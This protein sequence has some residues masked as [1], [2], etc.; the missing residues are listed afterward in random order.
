MKRKLRIFL[1]MMALPVLLVCTA[2]AT[3]VVTEGIQTAGRTTANPGCTVTYDAATGKYTASTKSGII[4]G[5]QYALLVVK[6]PAAG[7]SRI[8]SE[9]TVMYIDQQAATAEGVTFDFIPMSTPNCEVLLGG[10]FTSGKSLVVLGEMLGKGVTVRGSVTYYRNKPWSMNISVQQN[11]IETANLLTETDG[12]FSTIL[13]EGTYDFVISADGYLT[14][15]QQVLVDGEM[16][17][18]SIDCRAYAGDTDKSGAITGT[19]LGQLI[20]DYNKAPTYHTDLDNSGSVNGTDLSY[21]IG[22]YNNR[23][24]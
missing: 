19:D 14:H 5:E 1:L 9:E 10:K 24:D 8:V 22:N 2:F 12:T 6:K 17:N 23:A 16:K 15:T 4:E 13:P 7:E 21:L 20:S 11:G 18:V 3:D